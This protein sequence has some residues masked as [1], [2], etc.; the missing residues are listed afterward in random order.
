MKSFSR[1]E[2]LM[3]PDPRLRIPKNFPFRRLVHK[4]EDSARRGLN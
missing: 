4:I 1:M 2:T 3:A